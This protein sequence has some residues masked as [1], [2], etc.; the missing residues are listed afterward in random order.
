MEGTWNIGN[1]YNMEDVTKW[2]EIYND[3]FFAG[4]LTGFCKLKLIDMDPMSNAKGADLEGRYWTTYSTG[5]ATPCKKTDTI[6]FL[7]TTAHLDLD[8]FDSLRCL[9]HTLVHEMIHAVF[10]ICGCFSAGCHSSRG[11]SHGAF[12]QRAAIAIE[13]SSGNGKMCKF[14]PGLD[15]DRNGAV[16]SDVHQDGEKLFNEVDIRGLQLDIVYILKLMQKAREAKSKGYECWKEETKKES[17]VEKLPAWNPRHSVMEVPDGRHLPRRLLKEDFD[18]SRMEP[19]SY[20]AEDITT[21]I[22]NFLRPPT[23]YCNIEELASRQQRALKRLRSQSYW[24]LGNPHNLEDVKSF[25]EIYN[26]AYFSGTLTGYCKL[27]LVDSKILHERGDYSVINGICGVSLPGNERDTRYRLKTPD[28]V[29]SIAIQNSEDTDGFHRIESYHRTLLHQMTHALFAIYRCQC[30]QGC[31]ERMA[32]EPG[33]RHHM[34]WNAAAHAIEQS[35]QVG[36]NLFGL[37]TLLF[38]AGNMAEDIYLK[39][40]LPNDAILRSANLDIAWILRSVKVFRELYYTDKMRRTKESLMPT[41]VRNACHRDQWTVDSWNRN[42]GFDCGVWMGRINKIEMT[43]EFKSCQKDG[44]SGEDRWRCIH[45]KEYEGRS[46][47]K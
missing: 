31:K 26:D 1:I 29:I 38:R 32:R 3:A 30:D 39:S 17:V 13:Q 23:Y 28:V 45:W 40:P 10:A 16:V 7:S 8:P 47:C 19:L 11:G 2:F 36:R 33:G 27:E 43:E 25:F 4:L 5:E 9:M 37:N 6:I 20:S 22:L 35:N 41:K 12:W 44:I 24:H 18:L 21:A 34:P 42:F 14:G 15:L 46:V